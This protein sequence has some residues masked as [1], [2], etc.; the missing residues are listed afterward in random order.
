MLYFLIY[1]CII[2]NFEN[3]ISMCVFVME[4]KSTIISFPHMKDMIEMNNE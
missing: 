3:I 2:Y 1:V 4:R